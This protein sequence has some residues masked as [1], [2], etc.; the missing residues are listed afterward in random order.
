MCPQAAGGEWEER[1]PL[2][3][4]EEVGGDGRGWGAASASAAAL[5]QAEAGAAGRER[6][7]R[8]EEVMRLRRRVG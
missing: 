3:F 4:S 8:L 1:A 7:G 6:E 5:V 2:E